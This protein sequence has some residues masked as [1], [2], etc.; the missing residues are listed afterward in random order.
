MQLSFEIEFSSNVN[1]IMQPVGLDEFTLESDTCT[2]QE[3]LDCNFELDSCKWTSQNED[4]H[5]PWNR[6]SPSDG[7]Y[8][9]P[10]EFDHTYNSRMGKIHIR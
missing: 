3:V 7:N 4:T 2:E 6:V 1:K 10:M 8:M 5:I 9:Y